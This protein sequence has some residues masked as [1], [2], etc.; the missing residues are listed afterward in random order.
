MTSSPIVLTL[1]FLAFVIGVV[2]LTTAV[3]GTFWPGKTM[4]CKRCG[5][6]A[7][8]KTVIRGSFL[9]EIILWLCFIVPGIIYTLWRLTTRA[10]ACVTCGST[11]L[12]PQDSPAGKRLMRELEEQ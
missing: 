9:I 10:K 4:V 2:W 7:P 6:A 5:T 11:D 8:S 1:L 12:V 3:V